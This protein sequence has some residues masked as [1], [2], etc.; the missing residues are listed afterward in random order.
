MS[1]C[2]SLLNIIDQVLTN[3][4]LEFGSSILLPENDD[5]KDILDSCNKKSTTSDG[6]DSHEITKDICLLLEF[7]GNLLRNSMNKDV[8]NSAEVCCD[9]DI[10]FIAT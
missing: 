1:K 4:I 3:I 5:E 10:V 6:S 7:T 9:F 8:Y 2:T